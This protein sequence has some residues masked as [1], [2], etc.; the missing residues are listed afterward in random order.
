ME[1]EDLEV[2]RLFRRRRPIPFKIV[3][4]IKASLFCIMGLCESPDS[5]S[6]ETEKYIHDWNFEGLKQTSKSVSQRKNWFEGF[7]KS[8]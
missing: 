1:E 2:T 3:Q 7:I 4:K 6:M 5:L 8:T